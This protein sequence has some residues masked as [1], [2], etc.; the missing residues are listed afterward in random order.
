MFLPRSM[1]VTCGVTV[2][3]TVRNALCRFRKLALHGR[4]RRRRKHD[5]KRTLPQSRKRTLGIE[6]NV[7]ITDKRRY[8]T[9]ASFIA[10]CSEF[11]CIGKIIL[12]VI[13]LI[14]TKYLAYERWEVLISIHST[15]SEY[16]VNHK[17]T[18]HAFTPSCPVRRKLRVHHARFSI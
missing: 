4:S 15:W 11:R 13:S 18:E 17:P 16:C 12:T 9:I 2:L 6:L 1:S 10:L 14:T 8:R 3:A 5:E 7:R